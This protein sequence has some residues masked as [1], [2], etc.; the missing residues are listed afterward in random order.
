M[1]NQQQ[2]ISQPAS[3]VLYLEKEA[4]G[5]IVGMFLPPSLVSAFIVLFT[6]LSLH[7]S[8]DFLHLLDG[9]IGARQSI[10]DP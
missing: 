7:G 4:N 6:R 10:F 1:V 2:N 8:S 3:K 5:L 9:E